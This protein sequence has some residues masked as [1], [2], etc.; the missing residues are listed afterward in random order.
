MVATSNPP[1]LAPTSTSSTHPDDATAIRELYARQRALA[2]SAPNQHAL[3][4][5][6]AVREVNERVIVFLDNVGPNEGCD[7][8]AAAGLADPK[9]STRFGGNYLGAFVE[10][11][12]ELARHLQDFICTIG[13]DLP[14]VAPEG[15]AE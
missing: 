2:R 10:Q 9:D 1:T 5:L 12:N 3:S 15:G 11:A 7:V 4:L 6:R 13:G 8:L 14:E